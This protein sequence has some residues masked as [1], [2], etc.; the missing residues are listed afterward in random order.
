LDNGLVSGSSNGENVGAG[1]GT[2]IRWLLIA[3]Q[4]NP[5]GSI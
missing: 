3:E 4:R 5:L 2:Q 1:L